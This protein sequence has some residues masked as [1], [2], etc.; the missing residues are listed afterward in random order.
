MKVYNMLIY[1]VNILCTVQGLTDEMFRVL[2]SVN[3]L[4]V[5]RTMI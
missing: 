2:K 1:F 3:S 5:R 4:I